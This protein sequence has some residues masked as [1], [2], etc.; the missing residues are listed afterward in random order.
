MQNTGASLKKYHFTKFCV[1][2]LIPTENIWFSCCKRWSKTSEMSEASSNVLHYRALLCS[3]S[4]LLPVG[5]ILWYNL[6]KAILWFNL[7]KLYVF[8]N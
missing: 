8:S 3:T 5:T 2:V 7:M 6:L 4:L 1:A